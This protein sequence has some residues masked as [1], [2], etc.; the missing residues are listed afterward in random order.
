MT[1]PCVPVRC[2]T[3]ADLIRQYGNVWD[4][5]ST[6]EQD[7]MTLWDCRLWSQKNPALTWKGPFNRIYCNRDI[8]PAL[9]AALTNLH[10]N[11]CISELKTFDGCWNIRKVRGSETLW[12]LHSFAVALDF[13][14]ALNPLGEPTTFTEAFLRSF[15]AAGFSAGAR[16][17]RKDGMHF[18][19]AGNF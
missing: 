4:N 5:S 7:H 8:I 11:S 12:S 14:A 17:T 15:E 13:N 9:D 2:E 1:Q 10:L 19:F 6:F 3:M 18:Q 16:F